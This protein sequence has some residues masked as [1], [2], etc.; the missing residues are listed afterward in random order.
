M[1]PTSHTSP[2]HFERELG[3]TDL[4]ALSDTIE[5]GRSEEQTT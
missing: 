3:A 4:A 1:L 2:L 5:A